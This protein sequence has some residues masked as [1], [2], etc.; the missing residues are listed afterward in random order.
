MVR[1]DDAEE[2]SEAEMSELERAE[3][4][5]KEKRRQ[6]R[7]MKDNDDAG[8]SKRRRRIITMNDSTDSE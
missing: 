6:K 2:E 1:S 4:I 8:N 3:M 5:L 7:K